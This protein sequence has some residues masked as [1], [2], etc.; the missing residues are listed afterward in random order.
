MIQNIKIRNFKS[1][2]NFEANFEDPKNLVVIYGE[3]GSGKTNFLHV[4]NAISEQTLSLRLVNNILNNMPELLSDKP[5]V[6]ADQILRAIMRSTSLSGLLFNGITIGENT[7]SIDIKMEINGYNARY[8]LR[9]S[10]ERLLEEKLYYLINKNVS[11]MYHIKF[12]EKS[13]TVM[14]FFSPQLITTNTVLKEIKTQLKQ[15]W[16]EHSFLSILLYFTESRNASFWKE[17]IN[18]NIIKVLGY[19]KKFHNKNLSDEEK[20]FPSFTCYHIFGIKELGFGE[21]EYTEEII[22]ELDKTAETLFQYLSPLYR[23]LVD[24]KYKTK[25]SEE[26]N[27]LN[28]HLILSKDING[29]IRDI[30]YKDE[31]SGTKNLIQLFPYLLA[32]LKGYVVLI[33]EIEN[34]THDLLIG[35]I[36]SSLL[37]DFENHKGQIIATTHNTLIMEESNEDIIYILNEAKG[38]KTIERIS[39]YSD[40]RSRETH[41]LRKRYLGGLYQGIPYTRDIDFF[42]IR[43]ELNNAYS[44]NK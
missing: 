17:N 26:E 35:E 23:D 34:S 25:I 12:D 39:K 43:E 41:N 28:Y 36:I 5:N 20:G 42:E 4:L 9:Y 27:K 6:T 19:F 16:G 3:N 22:S 38:K 31:S 40:V 7:G 10:R 33:D 32:Y 44:K 29:V 37:A 24:V 11:K 14:E 21:I 1:L 30:P 2:V 8:V 18:E 15:Y 13:E